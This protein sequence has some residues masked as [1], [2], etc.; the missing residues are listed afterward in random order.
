[1]AEEEPW[2]LDLFSITEPCR[3][4]FEVGVLIMSGYHIVPSPSTALIS[5]DMHIVSSL[6]VKGAL[7][8]PFWLYL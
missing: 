8:V 5:M 1:M 2:K 7:F 3:F 4:L 6:K